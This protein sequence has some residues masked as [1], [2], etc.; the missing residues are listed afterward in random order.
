MEIACWQEGH[1]PFLPAACA[2][3]LTGFPH[4]G[5]RNRIGETASGIFVTSSSA[6]SKMELIGSGADG[7][8]FSA[9]LVLPVDPG[10]KVGPRTLAS[11]MWEVPHWLFASWLRHLQPVTPESHIGTGANADGPSS[12]FH[13]ATTPRTSPMMT[14]CLPPCVAH[15][16]QLARVAKP[17]A[18]KLKDVSS[19][20]PAGAEP[21]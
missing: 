7:A 4:D 16:V 3:A 11:E 1:F 13:L 6:N 12:S 17:D 18:G 2:G 5:H 8:E 10:E 20:L 19:F 9:R 14:W 15:E 21:L